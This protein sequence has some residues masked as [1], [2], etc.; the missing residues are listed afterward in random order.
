MA[1]GAQGRRAVRSPATT[2]GRRLPELLRRSLLF[3]LAFLLIY[4][5][6]F[7]LPRLM[8]GDPLSYSS[9]V[10]GEDLVVELSEAQRAELRAYYGLDQPLGQQF[11]DRARRHLRGDFGESIHYRRRVTALIAE[12]LPWTALVMGLALTLSLILGSLMAL[13]SFRRPRLDRLLYGLQSLLAEIPA[14]LVGLILLFGVAARVA[15]LPLA[16]S[17]T[18]FADYAHGWARV[19]DIA[20]HALLPVTTLTLVLVP[21]FY[22]TARASFL[23][24]AAAPYVLYARA[25]GLSSRRIRLAYILRNGLAPLIARF[26]LSVGTAIGASLLVENVFAYSGLGT[27]MR[28]AVRYRDYLL[29]QGIFLLSTAL[30]LASLWLADLIRRGVGLDSEGVGR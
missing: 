7:F 19:A 5:I 28:E 12:R 27:L 26:F 16:G 8:P 4:V 29:I 10:A 2:G 11:L 30:V 20:R 9:Q 17:A 15:G 3:V 18:P 6:N 14:F 1:V 23:H 22:F 25:K 21:A 24:I 13:A